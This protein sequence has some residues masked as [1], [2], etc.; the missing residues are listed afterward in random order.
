MPYLPKT[1][2]FSER[3]VVLAVSLPLAVIGSAFVL[4]IVGTGQA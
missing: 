4:W 2:S 1:A 3:L